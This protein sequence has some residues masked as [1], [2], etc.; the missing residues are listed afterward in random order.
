MK[1][2]SSKEIAALKPREKRYSVAIENGLTLRVHPSGSKSWLVRVSQNGRNVDITLGHFPD[3]GLAQAKQ[4]AR[5]KQKEFDVKP[6]SG[7][8]LKDAFVLW[9]NLKRGRI[10]SYKDEKKRIE[11][12]LMR[13][14]GNRQLD[15]ITA[16]LVIK[17]VQVIERDGKQSTLKRILMRLRE[18]MELAVCAGYIDANP[19]HRVSRVFAPARSTAMPSVDW[20]DLPSTMRIIKNA[21]IRMQNYFLFSLCSMLRPGEVAKLEKSWIINDVIHIPA[22]EMKKGRP[23]RVPITSLMKELLKRE[24]MLSPHPKNKYIFAGRAS[25]SHISKQALAKWLH[26]SSLKGQLVAH[27]LRSIARCW[28]ADNGINFEIAEA[29]L[30]HVVGDHVYRA[31]QRSDFLESRK[32]VMERWSSY[33]LFCAASAGILTDFPT[34]TDILSES[35]TKLAVC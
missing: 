22:S 9:C 5:R 30:S 8:T 32:A 18:I 35:S 19:L 23:H 6:I 12:Y 10:V 17:T 4:A 11:F 7:Y 33:V 20:R 24:R 16:P 29:C 21:P 15:E 1:I 3:M 13:H 28:L 14:L 2:F 26:S 27:G 34:N 25:N 31:Y